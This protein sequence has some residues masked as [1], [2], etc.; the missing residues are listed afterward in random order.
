[1]LG[2][3]KVKYVPSGD[4]LAIVADGAIAHPGVGDGRMIPTLIVDTSDRPDIEEYIRIHTHSGPGDVRVQWA[5]IPEKQTVLLTLSIER[6]AVLEMM[7]GFRLKDRQGVLV[8]QILRVNGFYLLA[9]RPGDRLKA[10][11]GS[12]SVIME[13]PDTG[14]GPGWEKIYLKHT[15]SVFRD[16]GLSR[17]DAK[18][19]AREAIDLLRQTGG[20]RLPFD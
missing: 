6:P 12:N 13:V 10:V 1:M 20:L 18:L 19:R 7:I 16:R 17:T 14:F 3:P 9:G 15:I 8:D 11:L 4:I 2:R 5:N